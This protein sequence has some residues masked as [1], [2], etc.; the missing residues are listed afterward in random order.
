MSDSE[1]RNGI[2]NKN[3]YHD[4]IDITLRTMYINKRLILFIVSIALW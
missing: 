3:N 1:T 4:T 2:E